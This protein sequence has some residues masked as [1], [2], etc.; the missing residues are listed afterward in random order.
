MYGATRSATFFRTKVGI[1]SATEDLPGS[2]QISKET[3][4]NAM[5]R[6]VDSN[7]DVIGVKA[8]GDESSVAWRTTSTL[9]AK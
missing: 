3:S 4:S 2:R 9:L 8:G 7:D 5:F 6:K 1:G